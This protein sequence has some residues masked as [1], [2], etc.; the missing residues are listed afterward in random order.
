MKKVF[1]LTL[2]LVLGF[3]A[4]AQKSNID[5]NAK[6]VTVTVSAPSQE[7]ISDAS[8]TESV[9]FA[10]PTNM[11]STSSFRS[12]DDYEEYEA[13]ISN[14]DLQSNSAIGNRIAVWPNGAASFV[15][16]WD[17]SE[18]TGFPDRG[19]GYNHYD[20]SEMGDMPSTRVEEEKSGWPS[21]AKCGNGELLASHATGVNVYYRPTRGIGEWTLLKN[22]GA[23]LNNPTWPRIICSGE[24]DEWIH[25]VMCKQEGNSTV[26]YTNHV[27]YTRSNDLGQTW[28]DV[29]DLP[30]IDNTADG[31]Y[32]NNF[33]ADDYVMAANGNNVAILLGSYT[34]DV[35]YIISHD[36]GS[37]WE[38]Q[39]VAPYPIEGAHAYVY[40]E[41]PEGWWSPLCTSDNSHS[42]AIDDNG[43]VHVAF[44][45]FRWQ[46]KTTS[47]YTY[48]PAYNYGIVY[49]NSEYT[50]E[51]GGHEIPLLG[52]W[53]GDTEFAEYGDTLG[54]SLDIYR[55]DALCQADGGEHLWY[56]G[57]TTEINEQGDTLY[58]TSDHY[59]NTPW[60]YRTDGMC[61]TP[62]ISVDGRGRIAVIYSVMS[63]SRINATTNMYYRSAYV[64]CRDRNG[65]WFDDAINLS[66]E[67]EH[68]MDEVYPTTASPVAYHGEFWTYY[69]A[70][71]NQG[72]YLDISES[73]PNSNQ[74]VLTDNT[75]FAIK[76]T[77]NMEGWDGVEEHEMVNPL[78]T[79]RVFPNP[80]KDMMTVEINAS[81]DAEATISVYNITGQN[82][83]DMNVSVSTGINNRTINTSELSSGVYFVTV[84]ANGF[85]KTTKVVVK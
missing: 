3:S 47:Q 24:N 12:V 59:L 15:A 69:S 45:L 25:L 4:F 54:Y 58:Y 60:S 14:Y 19:A 43:V 8:A 27:Y 67:F 44:A 56:F 34:T 40:D 26:G 9:V 49:W 29:I 22:F 28:D 71:M 78:T 79:T 37:T 41:H 32:R 52:D 48:W 39:I 23:E 63:K 6:N 38:K 77:P 7:R 33:S 5:K 62:G 30:L 1:L 35:V 80:A 70:D 51:Q 46:P 64:S 74:A 82:V 76:I 31:D 73:Y 75:I 81:Q 36:N 50:N 11:L 55:V 61:T 53:S 16:T 10:V 57:Y 17:H 42:I 66:E 72:L 85:S 83:M 18:N 2:G 84:N 65:R 20:G 13:M 21:I 68:S